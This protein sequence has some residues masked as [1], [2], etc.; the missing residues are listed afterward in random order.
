MR[1]SV[2]P[3]PQRR[4][5]TAYGLLDVPLRV[6]HQRLTEAVPT[7]WHEFYEIAYV[8]AGTGTHR[9][10]G[11]S[12]AIGAG[13]LVGMTPADFHDLEPDPGTTLELI[14][15]IF[16]A[17]LL[18]DDVQRLLLSRSW[19]L[20]LTFAGSQGDALKADLLRL[21]DEESKVRPGGPAASRATLQRVLIDIIR[22]TGATDLALGHRPDDHVM[23]NA[24]LHLHHRFRQPVSLADVAAHAH[25]SPNYFSGRFRALTG[26]SFVRYRQELRLQFARSLIV[27]SDLPITEVCYAAGFNTLSHFE[28]AFR[29]RWGC[30]PRAVRTGGEGQMA[31]SRT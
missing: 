12:S 10:N 8:L 23:R 3:E 13:S 16:A 31:D 24:L 20:R 18:D 14:D 2:A 29:A 27:V 7:H 22:A 5:R 25:L 21:C 9:T 26:M 15:V 17:E 19:P 4:T 6:R 28:R 11:R 30:A 1:R